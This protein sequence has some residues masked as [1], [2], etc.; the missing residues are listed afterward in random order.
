MSNPVGK[1]AQAG[2]DA[3][4]QLVRQLQRRLGG[5][6]TG[7]G[8][9]EPRS[10]WRSVT[11]NKGAEEVMPDGRVPGPLAALGDRVEVQVHK[12][13]GGK[14]TELA[15]R[16]RQPEPSG[17]GSVVA[18]VSGD[19]PRQ[20]VRAALRQAKQLIEVGEVLRVDPTPHGTRTATPTGKL[21]ELA[22]RRSGGEG[23]L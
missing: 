23:V 11:I 8:D 20:Q 6:A 17:I 1:V 5:E 10:R 3:A 14:G 13:A 18:R 22:T 12:A 9:G 21:V 7:A 16:L 2:L 4:G 19:D 15:A